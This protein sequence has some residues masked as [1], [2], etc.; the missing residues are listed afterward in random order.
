MT[1]TRKRR[2]RARRTRVTSEAPPVEP[3]VRRWRVEVDCGPYEAA[4]TVEAPD[5]DGAQGAAEAALAAPRDL[6]RAV[7]RISELIPD[8]D[9]EPWV[10]CEG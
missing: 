4:V 6:S 8:P 2:R 7:W 9:A 5:L 10:C 3:A 1:T